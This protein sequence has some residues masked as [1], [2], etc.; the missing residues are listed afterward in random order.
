MARPSFLPLTL[1]SA[2]LSIASQVLA[3]QTA[4]I[5]TA[6]VARAMQPG[7]V[8]RLDVTCACE[9]ASARAT[10]FGREVPLF[11]VPGSKVWRGLVGIDVEVAPGKYPIHVTVTRAGEPPLTSTRD[12]A[13]VAKR[14]PTRRLTV[15]AQ[16]VDPPAAE[17]ERIQTEARRLQKLFATVTPRLLWDGAI[18]LPLDTTPS[19]SFGMRSI[20]NGQARS[21]HG[22][23]DFPSPTGA[24]IAAPAG[25][26]IVLAE[27]LYF[28]GN[29]V[30]IDHGLG[31]YSLM[32]HMSR[33]DVK[34]GDTVKQGQTVGLVGATG[35]VTGPHL[36]WAVRLGGA[37]IDPLSLVATATTRE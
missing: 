31:L 11:P 19:G 32:A 29:T 14:F 28:T 2:L 10:A 21:P 24:P 35:R 15:A 6:I 7:E 16:F 3:A 17:V 5:D 9:P 4:A 27:E 18:Q 8:V 37:R 26:A 20:F 13:V 23:A 30:V 12:L 34:V 25:G 1:A 36:H 22:G 33:M